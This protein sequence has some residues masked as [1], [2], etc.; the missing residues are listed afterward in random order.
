LKSLQGAVN[1][2]TEKGVAYNKLINIGGWELKFQAPRSAGQ[3]P[4]LMHALGK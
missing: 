2:A 4:V 1:A 3:L